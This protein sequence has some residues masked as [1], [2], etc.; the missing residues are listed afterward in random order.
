MKIEAEAGPD[1]IEFDHFSV[2]CDFGYDT[3]CGGRRHKGICLR[4]AHDALSEIEVTVGNVEG[5]HTEVSVHLTVCFD[6]GLVHSNTIH[7]RGFYAGKL[8]TDP[9]VRYES[10]VKYLSAFS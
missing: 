1:F 5:P 6:V 4:E 3:G 2:T 8:H 10:R 9:R 7:A